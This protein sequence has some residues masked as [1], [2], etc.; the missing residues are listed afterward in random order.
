MKGKRIMCAVLA[1]LTTAGLSGCGGKSESAH[2]YKIGVL[3]SNTKNEAML[4]YAEAVEKCFAEMDTSEKRY[5]LTVLG[6]DDDSSKQGMQVKTLAYQQ[7]DALIVSLTDGNNA[8]SV[9]E[10]AVARF[11]V[12]ESEETEED[13]D[14]PD[15]NA[16]ETDKPESEGEGTVLPGDDGEEGESDETQ[17]I[18]EEISAEPHPRADGVSVPNMQS[19]SIPVVFT[20]TEPVM[21]NEPES[22]NE[23][24]ESGDGNTEGEDKEEKPDL[25]NWCAVVTSPE[26]GAM[27]LGKAAEKLP[28]RGDIN[29]DGVFNYLVVANSK[30]DNIGAKYTQALAE[31]F[32]EQGIEANCLGEVFSESE[33]AAFEKNLRN[34]VDANWERADAIFCLDEITAEAVYTLTNEF[35]DAESKDEPEEEGEPKPELKYYDIGGDFYVVGM[36]SAEGGEKLLSE[37][38]LSAAVCFEINEVARAAAEAV[39]SYLDGIDNLK[40]KRV[41]AYSEVTAPQED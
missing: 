16:P 9:I 19:R 38:K 5:E 40:I 10:S 24:A 30:K 32:N 22:E 26:D 12:S 21:K 2:V 35:H 28:S 20:F 3:V 13:S 29:S 17:P 15:E 41:D 31:Y 6:S 1:F 33:G 8:L 18:E 14:N 37:N 34:S 39:A 11:E 27:L 36:T 25:T 23:N 4:R 7:Y